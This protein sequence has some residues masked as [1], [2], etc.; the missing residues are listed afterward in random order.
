MESM[1]QIAHARSVSGNLPSAHLTPLDLDS[2]HSAIPLVGLGPILIASPHPDDET[3]GC[4]G[5]IARCA[6]L[7]CSVTVL[8]MTN[9]EAS[10]PGDTGWRVRLGETRMQEQRNALKTLGLSDP[11]IISM[12]LPDGGLDHVGHEQFEG[13]QDLILGAMQNRGVRT[14]FVPAV[15]DCHADHRWTARFLAKM[16]LR[17]PVGHFFSYQVWPPQQRLAGV[18]ANERDYAHD[19]SDLVGL[20][21]DAINQHRSQLT[22]IDPAHTEGFRMPE[23]LLEVKLKNEEAFAL[24]GDIAA[25]SE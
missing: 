6:E 21:R 10:H 22:A 20:K 4:G 14:L 24:V 25:W 8:A 18:S 16:A 7:G 1:V 12:G 15:D 3:L 17:H 5:L 2:L 13:L 9:G 11:D 23:A 19:I